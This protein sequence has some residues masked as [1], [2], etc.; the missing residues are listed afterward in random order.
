VANKEAEEVHEWF[1]WGDLMAG[2][3]V[4]Y[5]DVDARTILKWMGA[6]LDSCGLQNG[7]LEKSCKRGN[8]KPFSKICGEFIE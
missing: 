3:H 7:Q 2:V 1:W 8:E 5:L 4:E 6:G